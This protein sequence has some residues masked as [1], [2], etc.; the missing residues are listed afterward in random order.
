MAPKKA[1][2]IVKAKAVPKKA[3]DGCVRFRRG[4]PGTVRCRSVPVHRPSSG[5]RRR[6]HC[7]K[8]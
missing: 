6:V 8:L 2:V 7:R 4:F 5:L 3:A 1:V